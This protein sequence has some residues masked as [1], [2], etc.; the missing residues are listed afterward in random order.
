VQVRILAEIAK[1]VCN[2]SRENQDRNTAMMGK[3]QSGILSR[4]EDKQVE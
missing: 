1:S 4:I 3:A 2:E